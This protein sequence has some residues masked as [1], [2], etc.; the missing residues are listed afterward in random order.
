MQVVTLK[1]C[2]F[3]YFFQSLGGSGIR[4]KD[5]MDISP[6]NKIMANSLLKT[7]SV[8]MGALAPHGGK[9]QDNS[10]SL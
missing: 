6:L 8:D 4:Y 5:N 1:L 9:C 2:L 7:H 10:K 3:I